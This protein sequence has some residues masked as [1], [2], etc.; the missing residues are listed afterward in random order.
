[1]ASFMNDQVA[2]R[3]ADVRSR[4][5]KELGKDVFTLLIQANEQESA[6]F[7]MSDQELVRVNVVCLGPGLNNFC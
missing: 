6:R 2:Q 1:M 4:D 7:K 5:S 3:R